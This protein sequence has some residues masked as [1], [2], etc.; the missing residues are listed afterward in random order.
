V[1]GGDAVLVVDHAVGADAVVVGRTI[2][3]GDAGLGED[4]LVGVDELLVGGAGR[5]WSCG[6]R[7]VWSGLGG[8]R[9]RGRRVGDGLLVGAAGEERGGEECGAE[10]ERVGRAG[11]GARFGARLGTAC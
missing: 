9:G 2:P 7:W 6:M 8:C 10:R 11:F 1:R 3:A 5:D 4:G